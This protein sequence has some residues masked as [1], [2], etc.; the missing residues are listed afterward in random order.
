MSNTPNSTRTGT[1]NIWQQNVNK[2]R[3]CQHDLISS[4]KLA[5]KGIDI[6]AL[7]EPAINNFGATIASR[8]W[9]TVYSTT[10]GRGTP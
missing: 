3:V 1:F 9:I 7:Q 2:S 8:D 4:A 6:V 5:R 10:H